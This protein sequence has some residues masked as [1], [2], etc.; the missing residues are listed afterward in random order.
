MNV[1]PLPGSLSAVGLETEGEP[2]GAALARRTGHADAAAHELGQ[3]LADGE[4]QA[5]SAVPS[6]MIVLGLCE[7]IEYACQSIRGDTDARIRDRT[8]EEDATCGPTL[9]PCLDPNRT[10][11]S[12]F[13]RVTHEVH[14]HLL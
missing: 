10:S 2:E 14:Q 8:P 7:L 13:D 3:P 12:E 4:P 5:T 1:L 9:D 11:F 6:R